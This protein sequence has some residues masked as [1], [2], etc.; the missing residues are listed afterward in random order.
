MFEDDIIDTAAL[1]IVEQTVNGRMYEPID[2]TNVTG[3]HS[4]LADEAFERL[5][6]MDV[7]VEDRSK[8][9][10]QRWSHESHAKAI[11][12][13]LPT[14]EM[15][16]WY[17]LGQIHGHSTCFGCRT[18][19]NLI[20]VADE[21]FEEHYV[22]QVIERLNNSTDDRGKPIVVVGQEDNLRTPYFR[23]ERH[24]DSEGVPTAITTNYEDDRPSTPERMRT[25]FGYLV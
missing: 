6:E 7:V 17:V 14:V 1:R 5:V 11:F 22:E 8:I 16:A 21:C 20:Q 24:Y 19:E 2:V 12:D 15:S 25:V 23:P 18:E 4:Q 9:Q 13:E 3:I 10:Y